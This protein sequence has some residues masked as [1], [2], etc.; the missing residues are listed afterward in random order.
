MRR[1]T[2]APGA[3]R[4]R[5]TADE[6]LAQVFALAKSIWQDECAARR[7]MNAPHAEFDGQTPL[8]VARTEVGARRVEEGIEGGRQGLPV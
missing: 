5:H 3:Q 1:S 6:L 8:E 4:D 7:F 2:M